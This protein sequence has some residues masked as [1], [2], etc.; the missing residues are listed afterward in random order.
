MHACVLDAARSLGLDSPEGEKGMFWLAV[1]D[2]WL[3]CGEGRAD[4][5][6]LRTGVPTTHGVE[7]LL[8]ASGRFRLH[9]RYVLGSEGI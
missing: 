8:W 5:G 3:K 9:V 4:L 2:S 1:V 6:H 7:E